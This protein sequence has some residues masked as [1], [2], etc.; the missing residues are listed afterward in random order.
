MKHLTLVL[1]GVITA[2][3]LCLVH[4]SNKLYQADNYIQALEQ[5]F[6]EYI[7]ITAEKDSYYEYYN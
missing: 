7:D 2:L 5:D 4:L 3:I 1:L 6:P